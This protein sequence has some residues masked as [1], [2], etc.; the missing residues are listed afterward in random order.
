MPATQAPFTIAG[1]PL[2]VA[3]E[4]AIILGVVGVIFG[5]VYAWASPW[6]FPRQTR[7]GLAYGMAHGALMPMALPSLLIGQDVEIYAANNS[8]R[9]YKIGYIAGINICGM[10]FF[11]SAFLR[12]AKKPAGSAASGDGVQSNQVR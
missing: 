9:T 11:G 3:I 6:V 4:K 7:A 5:W 10:I 1:I 8:G 2:R 12:P